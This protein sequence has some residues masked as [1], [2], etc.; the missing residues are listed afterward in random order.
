MTRNLDN[1]RLFSK[2]LGYPE[3]CFQSIHVGGTNGKGTVVAIIESILRCAGIKVGM[4]T[5]PHLL[6]F[7]ERIRVGGEPISEERV[8]NFLEKHWDFIGENH[9]TFFEVS[10]AMALDTFKRGVVDVAV[11]EVGLGGTFDATR[12]VPSVLSVITR[13]DFDHTD[14]LGETLVQIAADKAGIFRADQPSVISDQ[15]TEVIDVLRDVAN[16]LGSHF[17]LAADLVTIFPENATP[18][19][20]IGTAEIN[21]SRSKTRL[22]RFHFPLTGSFQIDNLRTALAAVHLYSDRF[23]ALSAEVLVQGIDGVRWLGR[24]QE[25]RKKPYLVVDVGHNPGAV[26]EALQAIRE[27]WAPKRIIV[28]FSALRD[29]DVAAMMA[30]L[31]EKTDYG[32]IVPLPPPRGLNGDELKIFTQRVGWDVTILPSVDLALQESLK[33]VDDDD[34]VLTIGSH[35]LVEEVLKNQKYS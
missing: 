26:R 15:Q 2:R 10:T 31:K 21:S 17:Y 16:K 4:Y 27:I 33:I 18:E 22:K 13:I 25:L 6:S 7:C 24:L 32:F 19:G 23:G 29:K 12:I 28:V 35:Y 1:I 5:S 34:L 3:G 20:I 30:I 14:R 11:V 9:C 8:F